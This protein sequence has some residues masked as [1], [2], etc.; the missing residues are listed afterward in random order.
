MNKVLSNYLI[1]V[2]CCLFS[3]FTY[4]QSKAFFQAKVVDQ[5]NNSLALADVIVA[6]Q[7]VLQTN[8]KGEFFI[9]KAI[10][11]PFVIQISLPSYENK[12]LQITK[13]N[14]NRINNSNIILQN[15]IQELQE[16]LVTIERDNSYLSNSAVLSGKY[17]GTLKDLPQSV[18]LVS[19][20]LMQDKQ[21]FQLSDITQDLA[22]VTQASSYDEFVIRGFKSGYDTGYRLINGMRSAYGFGE[23]YYRSP[24][25]LNLESIEVLKGPG[26]SLFGDI[27]PG[28]TINMI[29]KKPQEEFGGNIQVAG[30]SFQTIRTSLD[31]TGALSKDK[32]ALYRLNTGYE[33]SKT[34]RDI[35]NRENF[36]FAP[37]FVF[38]PFETTKLEIDMVFDKFNGYLDRGM[39]ILSDQLY[40]LPRSFTLSQPSD[41]FRTKTITL[42][43]GLS[44]RITPDLNFHVN[45]M[46]S[47]YQEDL[48]EHRTLN[49]FANPPANTIVNLR[50]FD[51][52][53]KEYTNNLVSYLKWDLYSDNI[54]NHAIV[55]VDYASYKPDK[56]SYQR[57]A[58]SQRIDGQI[59]PLTFNLEDPIYQGADLSNYIWR[60]NSKYP[61]MSPYQSTGIYMQ[62]QF[63]Y[64]QR[65]KVLL[66]LRYE[67]HQSESTDTPIIY[68][69]HQNV[70][71]PKLGLTYTVDPNI[72]VFA[73]YSKGYVP[74]AA[75]FVVDYKSYGSDKPFKPESSF[76]V[77]TGVKSTFF[78]EQ[79]QMDLAV[80]HIA[81][82]NML[83]Q[84]GIV[85]D[86]GLPHYRQAGK[87]ISQGV[88]L[89]VRGQF[90]KALQIMANYTYNNTQ[91]K[92][93]SNSSE[94][95]QPLAGAPKNSANL[96]IKY[97]LLNTKFKGLGVGLGGYY[98]DQRR[99]NDSFEKDSQGNTIWGYLP[100]YTTFNAA[101]YYQKDQLK[102]SVNLNNIFDK[103]YF[104]GGFD[105]TR[106]FA[107][108]PRNITVN[109]SYH[110]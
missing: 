66:G 95:G 80:F 18:S 45:Y 34:F 2:I 30:G 94:D 27:A 78:K 53:G 81:R 67:N 41:Y 109:V 39:S 82:E 60:D 56:N 63:N 49:S 50:F 10:E 3:F 90:S 25:I 105:Y 55:A 61:F 98:V 26:A 87:V 8:N 23:S 20:E 59:V 17:S 16:V 57:E 7:L 15:Q 91:V 89:D 13:D 37:S 100:S 42:S 64:K 69:A 22:G 77:E 1:V 38:K 54:Q 83:M 5:D 76:Q 11:L 12:Y 86:S 58:R 46:Q 32:K 93:S 75:N 104:L 102:L 21:A 31:I 74:I 88:E 79:L 65:L 28:G 24:L 97:T 9:E 4:G 96:W 51:R 44:Q 72:N 85:G 101:M 36:L 43:A 107:G 108:S 52:H 110:F 62:N 70:W 6:N 84:T 33:T 35:N 103:Y 71:L 73:S 29:T 19:S 68:K 47:S 14:L 92:N 99:L 48:N 40:A 106:V